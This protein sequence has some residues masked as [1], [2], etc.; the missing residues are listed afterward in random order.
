MQA[1][2]T[3]YLGATNYRGARVVVKAQAGRVVVSWDHALD[4]ME[5]HRAA[6]RA[7]ATR[8]GWAG[9][10]RGGASSDGRGY[11]F[12]CGAGGMFAVH[13]KKGEE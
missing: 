13:A 8:Y 2:E 6:A 5:N 1:I 4:V 11:V 9:T 3:R 10:W 12:V 7:F